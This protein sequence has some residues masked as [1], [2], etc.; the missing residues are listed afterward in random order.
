MIS[1]RLSWQQ[2]GGV[3]H[4]I[5][6][7]MDLWQCHFWRPRLLVDHL[8]SWNRLILKFAQWHATRP[9]QSSI[10]T[11]SVDW[12]SL[13]IGKYFCRTSTLYQL[14]V[15]SCIL[16]TLLGRLDVIGH[17]DPIRSPNTSNYPVFYYNSPSLD[18]LQSETRHVSSSPNK[19]KQ[20]SQCVSTFY[21][22]VMT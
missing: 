8:L 6:S 12:V 15:S 17:H 14:Y 13:Y 22:C 7:H 19:S 1:F 10:S 20:H 16:L 2:Q 9:N 11:H 3:L 5:S 21:C 4:D 18:L